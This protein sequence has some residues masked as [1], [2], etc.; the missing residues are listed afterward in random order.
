M[1]IILDREYLGDSY[2]DILS[3][4]K[5]IAEQVLRE[6][7]K[8]GGL[9]IQYF[10]WSNINLKRGFTAILSM[11][12]C[13]NTKLLHAAAAEEEILVMAITDADCARPPGD[14]GVLSVPLLE[15]GFEM[16]QIL[17]DMRSGKGLDWKSAN[18]IHDDTLNRDMVSRVVTALSS[19]LPDETTAPTA[20]SIFTMRAEK[21][22]KERRE[23]IIEL[24]ANLP[25]GRIG[26]TFLVIIGRQQLESFMDIAAELRIVNTLTQWLYV[27]ADSDAIRDP[28]LKFSKRIGEGF[29]IAFVSNFSRPSRQECQM[30]RECYMRE[31]F[32]GF[33]HALDKCIAEER[34]L[35]NQ[36]SDEEWE[37]IRPN[38]RERRD[39]LLK[40]M[41][42][43][44]KQKSECG[45]CTR[46]MLRSSETW[47]RAYILD[48]TEVFQL[49]QAGFWR[50]TDGLSMTD[51]LFPHIMNGFR[52]KV[53]PIVT[54]HNPPWQIIAYNESGVPAQYKGVVFDIMDQLSINLNFSYSVTI[55][56]NATSALGLPQEFPTYQ[57][58]P[59]LLK[60]VKS[61]RVL[62][63][64]A[65]TTIDEKKK[66]MG[67]NFTMPISVQPYSFLVSRPGEL[68]R[69]LLFMLPFTYDTWLCLGFSVIVMGPLL[70]IMHRFSPFY[71][72]YGVA[73]QGG[74]KS[75]Q[76]CLWYMYGALLQQGGMH[77]PEAD[78]ARLIIGTWWLV[79]LVV[80]TTYCGNLVAFL[81][82]PKIDIAITSVEQLIIN[83]ETVSWTIRKGTYLEYHL[84]TTDQQKYTDLRRDA[85]FADSENEDMIEMVRQGKHVFVDWKINLQYIMKKEFLQTDGCDFALSSEEFIDERIGML[86]NK[87]SPY[88]PVINQELKR[89]H[90]MGLIQKWLASY[91]PKKDRCWNSGKSSEVQNHTVN[92]DDMQGSFFVLF[93]GF[94]L[95]GFVISAEFLYHKRKTKKEKA[96]IKPFVP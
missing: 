5:A 2:E 47:G 83:K 77:L 94:L 46:W 35:Y 55:V 63:G 78:S 28:V 45:N 15:P 24:L 8:N 13:H 58:P 82:F 6:E 26:K 38:R 37:S 11:A 18:I 57:L 32:R 42:K 34:E 21:H 44:I 52:G 90:Q 60:V 41:K 86:I 29:N 84:K 30:G 79:V 40:H 75:M 89:M 16:A 92:M 54:Y 67:V 72:Y 81:T 95:A 73:R 27:V 36:V 10:S 51:Y 65:A 64:A 43:F 25:M 12:N 39:A 3:T 96:I 93:L 9:N 19:E 1:A 88:L 53:M 14:F 66:A 49:I 59:S 20:V 74:L 87:D 31:Y 48:D 80:I 17:L 23:A 69:A 76:N 33:I 62:L 71:E 61:N 50:P 22:E 85:Q 70:Y 68:S 4:M 7:M 91:L 56:T